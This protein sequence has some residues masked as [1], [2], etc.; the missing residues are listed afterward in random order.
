MSS[1]TVKQSEKNSGWIDG[2]VIGAGFLPIAMAFGIIAKDF[3]FSFLESSMCSIL[4]F[5][6]ASQFAAIGM[7]ASGGAIID[8]I[9]LVWLVNMRHFL[10]GM[11]LMSIHGQR[12]K[13]YKPLLGFGLTDESYTFLSLSKKQVTSGYALVFQMMTYLAWIA[14]TMAGYILGQ[15]MPKKLS[16]SLD[17]ALYG[18]FASL[19]VMAVKENSKNFFII[20][21]AGLLHY[22]LS[23]LGI[24]DPSWNLIVSMVITSIIGAFIMKKYDK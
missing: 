13:K 10:M 7:L 6:G 14:G 12:L 18:M 24:L 4:V 5:A 23:L 17:I 16:L 22:G 8:V 9:L 20:V 2:M 3:G 11:S 1:V 19:A 21:I 15:Y